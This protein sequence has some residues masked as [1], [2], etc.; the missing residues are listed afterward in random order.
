MIHQLDEK[1]VLSSNILIE[2]DSFSSFIPATSKE[3]LSNFSLQTRRTYQQTL[4]VISQSIAVYPWFV[5]KTIDITSGGK[6]G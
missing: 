6:P 5:I 3:M 4:T 2:T 1:I